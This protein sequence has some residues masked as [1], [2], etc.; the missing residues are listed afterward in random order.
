MALR[1][2]LGNVVVCTASNSSTVVVVVDA[3][4]HTSC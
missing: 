3:K 1:Y 2:Q 4:R